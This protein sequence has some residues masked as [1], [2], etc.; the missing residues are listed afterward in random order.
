MRA[1]MGDF[2]NNE[3]TTVQLGPHQPVLVTCDRDKENRVPFKVFFNDN[4]E[5][6]MKKMDVSEETYDTIVGLLRESKRLDD[7][8]QQWLDHK[9]SGPGMGLWRIVRDNSLVRAIIV[10]KAFIERANDQTWNAVRFSKYTPK[11]LP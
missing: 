5:G 9:I 7:K 10:A 8:L 11:V 3:I 4:F 1:R 2:V 6:V